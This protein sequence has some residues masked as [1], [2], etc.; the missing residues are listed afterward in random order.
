MNGEGLYIDPASMRDLNINIK[1]FTKYVLKIANKGLL[2]FG[3]A[4]VNQAKDFIDHNDQVASGLLRNSGRAVSQPDGTVDAGFYVGYAEYVE[5][6]RKAG[7]MPPVDDIIQWLRRKAKRR[8][9]NSALRSATAFTGKSEEQLRRE[10]AWAIAT[11]IKRTGTKPH[12]FL[13][14]AYEMYR[15]KIDEFMQKKIN[16]AVEAFKPKK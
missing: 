13:K 5:Y 14:P 12:P 7:G 1:R 4:I 2:S 8:G 3:Q 11:S 16:E 10:A 9:K 6:G 15:N